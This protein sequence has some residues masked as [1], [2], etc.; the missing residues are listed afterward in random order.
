MNGCKN[1]GYKI[2]VNVKEEIKKEEPNYTL[3]FSIIGVVVFVIIVLAILFIVRAE[4]KRKQS[5]E[6][7]QLAKEMLEKE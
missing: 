6:T 4:M 7:T 3:I 2:S 1:D 5:N